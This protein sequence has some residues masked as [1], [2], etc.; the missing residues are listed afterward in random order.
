MEVATSSLELRLAP[1]AGVTNAPFRL[2]A[3]E[4]GAGLL[5]S[6]EIDA[7]ALVADNAHTREIA[8]YL[9]EEHPL[10]MQLLGADP[11]VLAEA[12][13]RLEAAGADAIDLNMGCPVAKI[14]AKGQG[15]ALMRDPW[16]AAVIFR[17]MRK[18]IT[19]PLTIKIRG[20][21]DDHTLNAIAIARL[22]ED[23]GVNAITVHP[24]TRSQQFSGRAPWD[25]L[26]EVVDAVG[27]P[28]TGNGDVRSRDDALAMQ[29]ATGCAA[30][31]IGRGALGAP[32]VFCAT[33][34]TDDGHAHIIRRHC[35]LIR[36][37]LTERA[38]LLQ[39]KKHLSW[40]SSGR[41][42]G[43][44]L[45]PALFAASSAEAVQAL[46]WHHWRQIGG[47]PAKSIDDRR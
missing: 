3:R 21:W 47:C 24:R 19:V 25:I 41:P 44:R 17:A 1:M 27:I 33:P 46:F 29:R 15:A 7:R 23:E 37:H 10:A 43:A 32:W 39:L 45:R 4:C 40:Y 5:T 42:F 18:A 14:V 9:P 28:I 35:T 12:A 6:E 30:V 13:R 8:H 38:A 16:R 22:A 20:G 2:V 34:T 36:E 11:D 31:M 26:A